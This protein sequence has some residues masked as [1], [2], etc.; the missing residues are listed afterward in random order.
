MIELST[1][2]LQL[3][4]VRNKTK[5]ETKMNEEKIKT[6][7]ATGL[8]SN[9]PDWMQSLS[10]VTGEDENKVKYSSKWRTEKEPVKNH[11]YI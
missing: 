2:S 7:A 8:K 9:F 3:K 6:S 5:E 10:C 4:L 1:N 11:N